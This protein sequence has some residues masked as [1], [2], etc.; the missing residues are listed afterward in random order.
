MPYHVIRHFYNILQ[1][2]PDDHYERFNYSDMMFIQ[3]FYVLSLYLQYK[4][5]DTRKY[6]IRIF[7]LTR[8]IFKFKNIINMTQ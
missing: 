8:L 3:S 7:V 5:F 6:C 4:I 1:K 2:R